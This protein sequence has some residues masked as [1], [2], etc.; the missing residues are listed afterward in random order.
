MPA[1]VKHAGGTYLGSSL[2][3]LSNFQL[4]LFLCFHVSLLTPTVLLVQTNST[5]LPYLIDYD[6]VQSVVILNGGQ[7]IACCSMVPPLPDFPE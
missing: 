1:C 7:Y 5:V 6:E 3:V 4:P 2:H